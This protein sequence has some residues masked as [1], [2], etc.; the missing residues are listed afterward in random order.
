MSLEAQTEHFLPLRIPLTIGK[1]SVHGV[2]GR[3]GT[4]V[5]V[6]ASDSQTGQGYAIKV[7]SRSD[8]AGRHKTE[9]LETEIQLAGQLHGEHICH[10]VEVICE[11]DLVFIVMDRY[12]GGDILSLIL[13]GLTATNVEC[14][15]LFR[16]IALGLQCLHSQGFAHGDL[17]PENVIVDSSGN[18]RLIDFGYSKRQCIGGDGDK[19]GTLMYGA[20]E[21][22]CPGKYHTQKADIWAL[23]IVPVPHQQHNGDSR[24]NTSWT[25]DVP[26]SDRR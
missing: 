15:R 6:D 4:S 9:Q 18:L 3:G 10:F 26:Q 21:L 11:G 5:V 1:Y 24:R 7:I 22:F 13:D 17:K 8:F 20:P 16:Q 25:P 12:E 23:G 19:S 2:I 14:I